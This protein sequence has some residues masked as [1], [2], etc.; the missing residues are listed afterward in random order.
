MSL[1][2]ELQTVKRQIGVEKYEALDRYCQATGADLI[3]TICCVKEWQNFERWLEMGECRLMID[4]IY[5]AESKYKPRVKVLYK[6]YNNSKGW[7]R[8]EAPKDAVMR[9]IEELG[10]RCLTEKAKAQYEKLK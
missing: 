10:E 1:M 2:Q 8:V 7:R 3:T 5:E 4:E 9:T 6:E